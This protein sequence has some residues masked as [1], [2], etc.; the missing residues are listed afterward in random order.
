M[1]NSSNLNKQTA[2]NNEGS[3]HVSVLLD[4]SGSMRAIA[5]DTIDGFN[6]FLSEQRDENGQCRVSLVQFDGQDTQHVVIDAIPILEVTD[7]APGDYEPRGSTPL[8]DAL[9]ILISRL[10]QRAQADSDEHQLVAVITDGYENASTDHTRDQIAELVNERTEAGWAFVFLGANIDA[11]GE[12]GTIGMERG[13]TAGWKADGDG[14][15]KS[16]DMVSKA[17]KRFRSAA[18]EERTLLTK[19]LIDE[20][21]DDEDDLD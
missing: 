11:F 7:L 8:L 16:F 4:R 6:V 9:G 20:I 10:D 3:V 18:K 19:S 13:Q 17:S 2:K 5:A 1:D 21:R 12:A 15:H 14:V